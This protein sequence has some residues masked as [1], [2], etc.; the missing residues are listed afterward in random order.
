MAPLHAGGH[1]T[2]EAAA[3]YGKKLL[4]AGRRVGKWVIRQVEGTPAAGT[5]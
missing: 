2:Q 4:P 1:P 5:G 3:T